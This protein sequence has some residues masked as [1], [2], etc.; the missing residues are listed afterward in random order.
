[1]STM[2]NISEMGYENNTST[3]L[4]D[5]TM[6][7]THHILTFI[8]PELDKLIHNNAFK[9]IDTTS[10]KT[11]SMNV[12]KYLTEHYKREGLKCDYNIFS[13]NPVIYELTITFEI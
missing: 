7:F 1:M 13:L 4:H 3:I 5:I 6:K 12:I 2:S 10:Y 9:R 11:R 8:V